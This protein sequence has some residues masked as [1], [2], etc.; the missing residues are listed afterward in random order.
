[1]DAVRGLMF[2]SGLLPAPGL[3]PG[4]AP[5][6]SGWPAPHRPQKRSAGPTAFPHWLQNGICYFIRYSRTICSRNGRDTMQRMRRLLPGVL[7]LA[8]A[9]ALPA[10]KSLEIYFIDVEGGQATLFV[11]AS[12]ESLLVDTGW[13]GFNGRDAGRIAAA[14]KSA[15]MKKIDYLV[16]THYHEDHVGGVRQL[17]AKLPIVTFVDHGPDVE[18]GQD[19]QAIF[20]AYEEFRAK[21]QHILARPGDTI[22]V[23]DL[24]VQVVSAAGEVISAPGEANPSCSAFREQAADASE[25]AQS[26]GLLISFGDF[27]MADLGDLTW[28]KEFGL[29]CPNNKIGH[30]NLFLASHHGLDTSNSPQ[31]VDAL[32]PR[33][34]IVN[35]GGRTG[36]SPETW[37][38]L[39]DAPGLEDIWQLHYAVGAP[40][41]HNSADP[42]IANIDEI[43]QG[44]WL[45]VTAQKDG[46]F[47]V[48]N[49]RNKYRKNYE[50]GSPG[51]PPH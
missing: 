39:H 28:N 41:D 7:L 32:A 37:Q 21:G 26:I 6:A 48:Y 31:L 13:G 33:V 47:T 2:A 5:A 36:A 12:G 24:Q 38:T 23:K 18:T 35:N 10:A 46:S 44:M 40:K 43:C 15:G 29:V 4:A 16:I 14:A 22:P 19:P 20:Q 50:E 3:A 27:R 17:A 1:M 42:Y 8:F 34:A 9:A 11:A 49:S 25:N 30:V 51:G 45:R